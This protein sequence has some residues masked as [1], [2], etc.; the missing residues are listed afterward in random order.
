[1]VNKLLYERIETQFL[2]PILASSLFM[3]P[4][5]IAEIFFSARS[6]PFLYHRIN[7]GNAVI[8][9]LFLTE[10]ILMISIT[11]KRISFLFEH[12]LE[13][14]IIILPLLALTRFIL[15]AKYLKISKSTYLLWFVKA[16]TLLNVY[17]AKSVTNKNNQTINY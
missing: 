16:Q 14:F 15:I 17:R 2:Y 13:L 11:K 9:G 3:M 12:W 10:F 6:H 4:F 7:L 8:W 1:L 5:W